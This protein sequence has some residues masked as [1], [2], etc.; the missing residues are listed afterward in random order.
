MEKLDMYAVAP[1]SLIVHD[2]ELEPVT[3]EDHAGGK[4]YGFTLK[5]HTHRN[6]SDDEDCYEG[7]LCIGTE[8]AAK[9]IGQVLATIPDGALLNRMADVRRHIAMTIAES[10]ARGMGVPVPLEVA[11]PLAGDIVQLLWPT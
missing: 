5:V 8:Q 11:L 2:L 9:L 6:S 4:H 1:S 10:M 7:N 3:F